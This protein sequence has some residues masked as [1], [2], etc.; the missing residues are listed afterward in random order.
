MICNNAQ[1]KDVYFILHIPKCAGRTVQHFLVSNFGD[2]C[3]GLRE[4][5]KS[6]RHLGERILFPARRKAP[7]RYFG[8]RY[9]NIVPASLDSIDFVFGFYLS[10]SMKA[11]FANRN[12][13]QAVLIRDPVGHFYSHYNFRMGKYAAQGMTPF[14]F[15]LWYK[16][17][18]PNPISKY[19]FSY[20]EIPYRT[21]IFLSD[22]AKLDLILDELSEFWHVGIHE[23]CDKLIER[24]A[25]DQGVSP[26]FEKRNVTRKKFMEFDNFKRLYERKIK[27]E[28][29]LDQ[30]IYKFFSSKEPLKKRE[31]PKVG[32]R[33]WRNILRGGFVP[34]YIFRYRLKRRYNI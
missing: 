1:S 31:R 5:D 32:G 6:E 10:K 34:W 4:R 26:K 28:N 20:L 29:G 27:E 13:K 7:Y 19:L 12:V 15:D 8:K 25:E 2:E 30:A 3:I 17:R 33:E 16:S 9:E 21:H 11:K 14:S 22:Q 24:I 18:R 23:E